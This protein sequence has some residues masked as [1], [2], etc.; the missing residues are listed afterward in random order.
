MD[1]G[2]WRATI[3]GVAESDTTEWLTHT[4][5]QTFGSISSSELI[6]ELFGFWFFAF[7]SLL[8]FF[9][10]PP[11]HWLRFIKWKRIR[12]YRARWGWELWAGQGTGDVMHQ[13][14]FCLVLGPCRGILNFSGMTI[15]LLTVALWKTKNPIK[16]GMEPR[17][18]YW[19]NYFR[20]FWCSWLKD[21]HLTDTACRDQI[22]WQLSA[23]ENWLQCME[24]A[25]APHSSTL[26]WKIPWT[27]KPW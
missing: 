15:S 12:W 26:A 17:D 21:H 25:M 3:C 27:E 24:K 19:N 22:L 18:L 10:L 20:Q 6:S 9:S 23:Q 7:S 2:T 16:S 13:W 8:G 4:H 11:I 14:N 1:R 5:T